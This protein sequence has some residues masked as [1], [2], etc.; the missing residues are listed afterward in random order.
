MRGN[1]KRKTDKTRYL[2]AYVYNARAQPKTR[3]RPL[4]NRRRM[5]VR[6]Y[7]RPGT[8]RKLINSQERAFEAEVVL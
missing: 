2:P 4:V 1:Q 5:R 6:P 3:P 8:V 7:G